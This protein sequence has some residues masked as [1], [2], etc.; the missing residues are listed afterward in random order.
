MSYEVAGKIAA[1]YPTAQKSAT[2]QTREFAIEKTDDIGGRIITNYIKFQT[3]QDKT[4][5]LDRVAVGDNVKVYFNLRGTKW[6]KDGREAY[7]TNLDAWRIES[8]VPGATAP[9]GGTPPP[10]TGPTAPEPFDPNGLQTS[11]LSEDSDLPF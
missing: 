8:F 7:I 6:M 9:A 4:M 5:L 1:I 3:V 2:F 10:A 11:N